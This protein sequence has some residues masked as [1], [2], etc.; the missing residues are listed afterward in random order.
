MPRFQ[1]VVR[2]CDLATPT[3]LILLSALRASQAGG[4][5]SKI[6]GGKHFNNR[7]SVIVQR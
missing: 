5:F 7:A 4:L 3:I 6:K 2:L 1:A